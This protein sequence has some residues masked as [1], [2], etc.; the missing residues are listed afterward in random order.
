MS[1]CFC[2]GV[3]GLFVCVLLS[4]WSCKC[5]S[6]R[7]VTEHSSAYRPQNSS[8]SV[9]MFVSVLTRLRVVFSFFC[10]LWFCFSVWGG[11]VQNSWPF[12]CRCHEDCEDSWVLIQLIWK[13]PPSGGML[14]ALRLFS[15]RVSCV[16][17]SRR[18]RRASSELNKSE[19]SSLITF[20]WALVSGQLT[21]SSSVS[22]AVVAP[23]LWRSFFFVHCVDAKPLTSRLWLSWS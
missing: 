11:S 12:P 5:V 3:F 4:V 23:G 17:V 14:L 20:K 2:V 19:A 9:R 18:G 1:I 10:F 22:I 15:C 16:R 6:V 13:E 8:R 7:C 21:F